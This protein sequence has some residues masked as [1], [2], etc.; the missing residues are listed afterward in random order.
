MIRGYI[1]PVMGVFLFLVAIFSP[2]RAGQVVTDEDRGWAK[3]AIEQETTLQAVPT[4]NTV[5]VLYFRNR[6]AN[7]GLNPLQKGFAF[8]LMTD[9]A[10]VD[11]ISL[12]ERVK[13]QALVEEMGL[14]AAGLVDKDTAP[15]MGKLLGAYYLVGGDLNSG[16]QAELGIKSDV[17]QV[18]D[19]SSLGQPSADGSLAQVFDLEKKILFD[20]IDLLKVRLTKDKK[21]KLRQ[22]LTKSFPAF[23]YLSD[24]LDASDHGNYLRAGF[25]YRKALEHDPQFLPAQ[26]ALNELLS[27]GLV[28]AKPRS[29]AILIEQEE[30]NSDE[31]NSGSNISTFREFRPVSN[32][33]IRVRW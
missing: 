16:T 4:S 19:Q 27:L 31:T 8:L 7:A 15:R 17:L 32:G 1:I 30:Q 29:H 13:L 18:K 22:P 2:A 33:D 5:A 11:G 12:V 24:G 10:Q 3:K 26:S 20:I 6:S 14:G 28:T 21:D 9:I 25:Y 23:V